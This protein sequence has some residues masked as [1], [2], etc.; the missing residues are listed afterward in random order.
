VATLDG[1]DYWT[2]PDKLKRQV[3]YLTAHPHYTFCFH[4]VRCKSDRTEDDGKEIGAVTA[5]RIDRTEYVLEDLVQD[6]FVPFGSV[7]ARKGLVANFPAWVRDIPGIDWIFG[8]L[9]ARQGPFGRVPECMGVYRKHSGGAWTGL[10]WAR[11]MNTVLKIYEGMRGELPQRLWPLIDTMLMN[12]RLRSEWQIAREKLEKASESAGGDEYRRIVARNKELESYAR[13][14]QSKYI[15]LERYSRELVDK[16]VR[17]EE[18]TR[19]LQVRFASLEESA[20]KQCLTHPADPPTGKKF[21]RL[22]K[23]GLA[24]FRRSSRRTTHEV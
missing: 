1:D 20:R 5:G 24:P 7:V 11:Q 12:I 14:L 2:S 22:K 16:F 10:T 18:Y 9:N 6:N 23:I 17:L 19:D 13:D 15:D 8:I 21:D 3:E 4:N